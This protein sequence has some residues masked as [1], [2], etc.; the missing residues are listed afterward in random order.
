MGRRR[1]RSRHRGARAP[2]QH[3]SGNYRFTIED[4]LAWHSTH[5]SADYVPQ[6]FAAEILAEMAG[7]AS[8]KSEE[9]QADAQTV[10]TSQS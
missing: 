5:H 4:T 6:K 7:S 8:D 1:T 2:V 3:V 9:T 10:C